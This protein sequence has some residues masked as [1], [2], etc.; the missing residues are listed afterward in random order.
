MHDD[1]MNLKTN[2]ALNLSFKIGS[3]ML[4]VD[5]RLPMLWL[6]TVTSQLEKGECEWSP[7]DPVSGPRRRGSF[8]VPCF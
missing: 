7:A 5:M 8:R 2:K 3:S 6:R 1:H 4:L